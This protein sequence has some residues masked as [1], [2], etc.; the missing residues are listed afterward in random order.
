MKS[1]STMNS[2]LRLGRYLRTSSYL[3][4][5][6]FSSDSGRNLGRKC[7]RCCIRRF[8]IAATGRFGAPC[9]SFIVVGFVY[10]A[11]KLPKGPRG[12]G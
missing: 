2:T 10:L 8:S 1:E 3:N 9:L 7:L 4:M 5:K 11:E 12:K 6:C